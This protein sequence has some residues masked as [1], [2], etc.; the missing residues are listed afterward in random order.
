MNAIVT[1]TTP[2]VPADVGM[3]VGIKPPTALHQ[4][5]QVTETVPI[6]QGL[7][8]ENSAKQRSKH[9]GRFEA[10]HSHSWRRG[11]INE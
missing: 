6:H 3:I 5:A 4:Q 1:I 11:G 7:L 9:V 2:K 10:R 8:P